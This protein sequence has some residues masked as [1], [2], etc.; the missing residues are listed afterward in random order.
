MAH[1]FITAEGITTAFTIIAGNLE[2]AEVRIVLFMSFLCLEALELL[3]F[4][5]DYQ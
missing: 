1:M 2:G 4:D 3:D 5:L